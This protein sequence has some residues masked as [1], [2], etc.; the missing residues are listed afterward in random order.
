MTMIAKNETAL[1]TGGTSGIGYAIAR[2]FASRGYNLILVSNQKERLKE[3]AE[4]FKAKYKTNTKTLFM[5]L[6]AADAA[7]ILYEW[8]Q[9]EMLEVDVLVNNAGIFYF[10]EVVETSVANACNIISLHVSTPA[11]LCILFGKDMKQ[12][13]RGNIIIISSLASYMPYPGIAFYAAT[14]RFLKS[15]SRS[16]RTE[17]IDYNVNV[18][19]ICP[20]AVSTNLYDLSQEN[21]KKAIKA[22]IMMRPEKL[23]K[24]ILNAALAG[25]SLIIPGI[26]NKIFLPFLFIIPHGIIGLIRRYTRFLPPDHP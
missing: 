14:K 10:G 20:G 19:C 13:R 21:H 25:K 5:D 26:S 17:M 7:V 24:K 12:R 3:V 4:E 22:G 15:F 2:E 8:C 16:L 18:T 6:A 1:V 23:A 9:S 11:K